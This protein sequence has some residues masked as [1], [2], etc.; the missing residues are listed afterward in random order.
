MLE[1]NID[2]NL[3]YKTV[4]DT[5]LCGM[6]STIPD[7][8]IVDANRAAAEI[9]GYTVEEMKKGGSSLLFDE[10]DPEMILLLKTRK[11]DG[12]AKG[13]V[14]GIRKNG[15][16]FPCEVST[17]VYVDEYGKNRATIIL[18]DISEKKVIEKD[19]FSK[20]VLLNAVVSNSNEGIAVADKNGHFLIFNDA[21][22]DLLGIPPVNSK[23]YD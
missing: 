17:S 3:N 9:F 4:F 18:A 10:A 21:M 11:S 7:G 14:T 23:T 13:E 16:R 5:A 8:T 19:L 22:I 6:L 2:H 1:N 20:H 15:Q 12:R